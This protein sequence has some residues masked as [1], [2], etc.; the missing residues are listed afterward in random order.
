MSMWLIAAAAIAALLLPSPPNQMRGS[1]VAYS[2]FLRS[3][4]SSFHSSYIMAKA[5][6][7]R[8][9]LDVGKVSEVTYQ[10]Y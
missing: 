10:Q 2:E 6:G 8:R 5:V 4:S 3:V 7:F 1:E 9:A